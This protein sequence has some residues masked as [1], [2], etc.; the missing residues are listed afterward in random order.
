MRLQRAL[1]PINKSGVN[2]TDGCKPVQELTPAGLLKPNNIN[3]ISMLPWV[4]IA[5]VSSGNGLVWDFVCCLTHDFRAPGSGVEFKQGGEWKTLR[6]KLCAV[7]ALGAILWSVLCRPAST[8]S[9]V[10]LV[11]YLLLVTALLSVSEFLLHLLICFSVCICMWYE[12]THTRAEYGSWFSP[13]T[14][15]GDWTQVVRPGSECFSTLSH[16]AG[17]QLCFINEETVYKWWEDLSLPF[18]LTSQVE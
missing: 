4:N 18:K 12:G 8:L 15:S 17:H 9:T 6:G 16:T 7:C 11:T 13:S 14:Y 10:H 1:T 5:P 2:P 3:R